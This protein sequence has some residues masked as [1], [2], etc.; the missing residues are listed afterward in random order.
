MCVAFSY[1]SS[2][3]KSDFFYFFLSSPL[4]DSAAHSPVSVPRK[5][6]ISQ[7]KAINPHFALIFHT[8]DDYFNTTL[9]GI[10]FWFIRSNINKAGFHNILSAFGRCD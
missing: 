3:I 4:D 5:G 9:N 8:L 10:L 1:F 7:I 2:R 6:I